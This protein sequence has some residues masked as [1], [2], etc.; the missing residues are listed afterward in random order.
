MIESP[1]VDVNTRSEQGL[2]QKQKC[3]VFS[4]VLPYPDKGQT[5]QWLSA[6][7]GR[8]DGNPGLTFCS[9]QMIDKL[10]RQGVDL[11]IVC[12]GYVWLP[13]RAEETF[14]SPATHQTKTVHTSPLCLITLKWQNDHVLQVE[15]HYVPKCRVCCYL[16]ENIKLN[17]GGCFPERMLRSLW[18]SVD[19]GGCCLSHAGDGWPRCLMNGHG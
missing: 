2:R 19:V 18:E 13:T 8:S 11:C 14:P 12:F 7:K 5:G 6:K 17:C 10:L 9:L 15:S 3:F 1:E 16:N 4:C